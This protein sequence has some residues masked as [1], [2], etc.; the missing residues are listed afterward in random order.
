MYATTSY[1]IRKGSIEER[2]VKNQSVLLVDTPENYFDHLELKNET[3]FSIADFARIIVLI[4]NPADTLLENFVNR[5]LGPTLE[6]N[7]EQASY[8]QSKGIYIQPPANQQQKKDLRR[9]LVLKSC[10]KIWQF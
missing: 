9:F 7:K 4:R 5:K 1:F 10:C 3:I 2:H 8:T 6:Y